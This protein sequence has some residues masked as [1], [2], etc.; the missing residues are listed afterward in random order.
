[1]NY[2]K[3]VKTYTRKD[4]EEIIESK[5][6]G[7]QLTQKIITD[8]FFE[9]LRELL[10]KA[11]PVA[12]IEIREF[13]VFEVKE[14]KPKPKARNIKTGEFVYVP[15]RRKVHFKPGKILKQFLKEEYKKEI[16]NDG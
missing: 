7:K 9:S 11:D 16:N 5:L 15:G 4:I 6:T 10:M 2:K 13:G 1:M 3:R 12:R 14:T 8:T